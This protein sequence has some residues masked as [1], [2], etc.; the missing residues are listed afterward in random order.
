MSGQIDQLIKFIAVH[1]VFDEKHYPSLKDATDEQKIIFALNHSALHFAK[2]AGKIATVAESV[3]HGAAIDK[4]E[5]RAN[6]SKAFINTLRF[7]ELVGM[8]ESDIVQAIE[9][10]Y[11]ALVNE[12]NMNKQ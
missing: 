8:S 1:L 3:D 4:E 9:K 5:L 6:V 11:G 10:K 7:A 2:T 12:F